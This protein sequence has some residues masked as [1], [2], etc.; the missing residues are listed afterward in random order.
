MPSLS[1]N[2][3]NG[4]AVAYIKVSKENIK[5][6]PDLKQ[7]NNQI[8]YLHD[9][10]DGVKEIQFDDDTLSVFPLFKFNKNEKQINRISVY[11]RSGV[12]KSSLVG[13]ILDSMKSKRFGEPERDICIISGIKEDEA[14]DKPRGPKNNKQ[15]PE[16]V[17]LFDPG[18]A[19]MTPEDFEKCIVIY[20]DVEAMTNK[21]VSRAVLNLRNTMFETSRH[22]GTDIISISH[23]C[24]AGN[25]TRYAN[26]ES[27]GFFLFPGFS[28]HHHI[29]TYLKKYG[30]FSKE[31]IAKVVNIGETRSRW[32]YCSNMSPTYVVH[33]KG[34]YLVR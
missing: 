21:A 17:D 30:G 23:N 18:F 9:T 24:I 31:A 16:R 10:N 29:Q 26:S 19:E 27:T 5:E 14:L 32:T 28:Q 22:F 7:F 4:K 15:L 2:P 20:D 13:K 11:G 3:D 1:F 12:G 25:L 33:E 8:I 6:K 34:V